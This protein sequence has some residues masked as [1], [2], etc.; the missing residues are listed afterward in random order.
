MKSTEKDQIK[1][2]EVKYVWVCKKNG[3]RMY[4]RIFDSTLYITQGSNKR[5]V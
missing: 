2:F 3:S 5:A 1:V 4:R